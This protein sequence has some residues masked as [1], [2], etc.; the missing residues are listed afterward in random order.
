MF[1]PIRKFLFLRNVHTRIFMAHKIFRGML[2]LCI[3]GVC[4]KCTV[5]F[6][7]AQVHG[8]EPGITLFAERTEKLPMA[9]I[10]AVVSEP[11]QGHEEYHMMVSSKFTLTPAT[12]SS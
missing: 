2:Y 5:E 7:N 12:V 3:N 1:R 9:S 10:K 6:K 4:L 8:A 11:L